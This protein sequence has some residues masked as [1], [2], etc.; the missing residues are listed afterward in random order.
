RTSDLRCWVLR[1]SLMTPTL[2]RRSVP[3]RLALSQALACP[4]TTAECGPSWKDLDALSLDYVP[5]SR[6][7]VGLEDQVHVAPEEVLERLLDRD[8]VLQR[9]PLLHVDRQVDVAVRPEVRPYCRT[10]DLGGADAMPSSEPKQSAARRQ[11]E[12]GIGP[13]QGLTG[14]DPMDH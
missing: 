12:E 10:E 3:N 1:G 9:G 8:Q 2:G 4:Q 7:G 13:P 14:G 11:P 6:P 5:G